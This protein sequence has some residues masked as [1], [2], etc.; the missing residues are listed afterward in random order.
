MITKRE[1]AVTQQRAAKPAC[2]IL[3]EQALPL[4]ESDAAYIRSH[5]KR[6]K[7]G[8]ND[9]PLGTA[10]HLKKLDRHQP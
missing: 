1:P 3:V 6:D 8:N 2:A 9:T 7:L 4:F 10:M 5:E